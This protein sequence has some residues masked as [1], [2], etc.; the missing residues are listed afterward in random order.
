LGSRMVSLLLPVLGGR[1]VLAPVGDPVDRGEAH[2][3]SEDDL[4]DLGEGG[5]GE[6]RH[7]L[8]PRPTF[9]PSCSNGTGRARARSCRPPRS[10]RRHGVVG[11]G[12]LG[13]ALLRLGQ[14]SPRGC[15]RPSPRPGRPRCRRSACPPSAARSSRRTCGRRDRLRPLVAGHVEGAG[16]HAVPAA[17][18]LV[19]VVDGPGPSPSW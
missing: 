13:D 10:R 2:G 18:A 9:I 4:G 15:R 19:G 5:P 1:D 7:R 6:V 17:H 11:A 8:L 16:D 3:A 12:V 14:Q